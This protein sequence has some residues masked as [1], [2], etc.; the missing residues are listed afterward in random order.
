MPISTISSKEELLFFSDPTSLERSIRKEKHTS[1]IDTTST[2]S[3][4]TTF[5]TSIDTTSTTSIDTSDRATIDSST[6]TSIDTNPRAD[7]VVSLMLQR[8]ENGDL[9]DPGGHQCNAAGQKIDGQGTAILEPFAAPEDAKV[10]L[11]RSLVDLIRFYTNRS[12][13]RPLKI[14]GF[15]I[16]LTHFSHVGRHPYRGLPDENPLDHIETLEDFVSGIQED[17]ATKDYIICKLFR[18]HYKK[19]A[20]F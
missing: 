7:I 6:R 15:Q 12:A 19:T 8:D 10:P 11:Q 13:I 3:I 5:T 16:H 17:E 1:S 4:D 18:Y 2:T 9:H 20:V 14:Q